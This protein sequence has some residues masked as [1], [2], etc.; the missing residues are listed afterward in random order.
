MIPIA[1][2]VVL[3]PPPS[4]ERRAASLIP[5]PNNVPYLVAIVVMIAVAIL[6]FAAIA[7]ARPAQDLV[8]LGGIVFTAIAPTTLALLAF[9]KAQETHLSVNSRLDA[10]IQNATLAARVQGL[11]DGRAQGHADANLRTDTLATAAATALAAA[12]APIGEPS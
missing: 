10:F 7:I 5:A 4:F 2:A 11:A 9:M 3:T 12:A 1:G 8:V 6:A